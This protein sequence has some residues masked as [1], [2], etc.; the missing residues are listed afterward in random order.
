MK[1]SLKDICKDKEMLKYLQ[2]ILRDQPVTKGFANKLEKVIRFYEEVETDLE[3]GTESII[4]LKGGRLEEIEE[5]NKMLGFL[6]NAD[7]I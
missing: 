2:S 7:D 1:V 5:R 6:N 4:E 3:L